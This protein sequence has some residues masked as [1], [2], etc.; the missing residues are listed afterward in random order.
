[1]GAKKLPVEAFGFYVGLGSDRSYGDVAE[2]YKVSTKTVSRL[3]SKEKWQERIL[4]INEEALAK[5]EEKSAI[6]LQRTE[7]S[8]LEL[9]ATLQEALTDV[10][11]PKRLK[12]VFATLFKAAVQKESVTAARILI[13]R[14]LGKIRNEPLQAGSIAIPNSLETASDVRAAA[15]ALLLALSKGLLAPEDALKAA[16][17]VESA[18]KS[19]ETEELEERL[20]KLEEDVKGNRIE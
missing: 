10:M 3:A 19:V 12:A 5:A 16:S 8:K 6:A 9:K 7:T 20:L 2:R 17:I 18:R 13:E 1:M 14:V 11:T 15:H 4:R